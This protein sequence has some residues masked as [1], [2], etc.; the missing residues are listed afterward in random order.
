[1]S[2]TSSTNYGDAAQKLNGYVEKVRLALKYINQVNEVSEATDEYLKYIEE[3]R[4]SLSIGWI[5]PKDDD[6]EYYFQKKELNVLVSH[7]DSMK[8]NIDY[9]ATNIP[10]DISHYKN[11]INSGLEFYRQCVENW[12][13]Q[14]DDDYA[15]ISYEK[16]ACVI[17][18]R[19]MLS[20]ISSKG[21]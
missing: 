18:A 8:K 14:C 19:N 7:I 1:M 10:I 3:I 6:A 11:K 16:S 20:E 15:K 13:S 2:V 4:N 21:Y 5:I 9:M 17:N 12:N